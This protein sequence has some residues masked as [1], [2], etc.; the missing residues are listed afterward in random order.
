MHLPEVYLLLLLGHESKTLGRH[1]LV[2]HVL[3]EKFN[4]INL[5][6]LSLKLVLVAIAG[7]SK[8]VSD[9]LVFSVHSPCTL[10]AARH[11]RVSVK[12]SPTL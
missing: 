3:Q 12:S 9:I 6:H 4:E 5:K 7:V 11:V 10:F 2:C 1:L 8:W